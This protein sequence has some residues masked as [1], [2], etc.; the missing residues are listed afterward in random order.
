MAE[1]YSLQEI[2]KFAIEI[3][4]EGILFYNKISQ[5]TDNQG[6]K[7]TFLKLEN[8]EKKH[9]KKFEE[10]LDTLGSDENEY[11]Y[12]LENEYVAYLHAIIEKSV[13]NSEEID[14]LIKKFQ[15]DTDAINYAISKE[16]DSIKFYENMKELTPKGNIP[17]INVIISEENLHIRDLLEIKANL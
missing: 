7:N 5:K 16:E 9:Q 3:E 14:Q 15:N 13:F 1:K 10:I 2:V 6:L 8:D 17:T 12:H 4:K 11:V